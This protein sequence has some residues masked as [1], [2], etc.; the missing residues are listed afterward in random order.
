MSRESDNSK[1][2]DAEADGRSLLL[3][4]SIWSF[5]SLVIAGFLA[6]AIQSL[7]TRLLSP[8]DVGVLALV[9]SMVFVTIIVS[10]PGIVQYLPKLLGTLSADKQT[11]QQNA[12]IRTSLLLAVSIYL[13]AGVLVGVAGLGHWVNLK[14]FPN[15]NLDRWLIYTFPL[16]LFTGLLQH[17]SFIYR[18]LHKVG[19]SILFGIQNNGVGYQVAFLIALVIYWFADKFDLVIALNILI[20]ATALPLAWAL[21]GI[22]EKIFDNRSGWYPVREILAHSY[23]IWGSTIGFMILMQAG[24]WIV[25]AFTGDKEVALYISAWRLSAFVYFP[26][27]V[28]NAVI[29]PIVARMYHQEQKSELEILLRQGAT[30]TGVAS[31]LLG[32]VFILFAEPILSLLFGGYYGSAKWMLVALSIGQI[33]NV[34]AGSGGIVLNMTG[35]QRTLAA[36]TLLNIVVVLAIGIGFAIPFGAN[37]VAFAI[38]LALIIQNLLMVGMVKYRTGMRIYFAFEHLKLLQPVR[39][40][41]FAKQFL[42]PGA[43]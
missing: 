29:P 40:F 7:L 38:A 20:V 13:V 6:L 27:I 26:L 15:I 8:S 19:K 16:I 35:H 36:L 11:G 25:G 30:I 2:S 34:A 23:P 5:F 12:V 28:I 17:V 32:A 33:V 22:S 42:G 39:L 41:G 37:G 43:R 1:F 31:M 4:G 10:D 24:V 3:S 21:W 18:G 14:V 9:Q